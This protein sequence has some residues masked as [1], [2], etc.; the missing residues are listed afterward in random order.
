M[1]HRMPGE[2][3]ARHPIGVSGP[4]WTWSNYVDWHLRIRL[5]RIGGWVSTLFP[6]VERGAEPVLPRSLRRSEPFRPPENNCQRPLVR[7]RPLLV[8]SISDQP[9][10][11]Y[12]GHAQLTAKPIPPF[13]T[14]TLW[15]AAAGIPFSGL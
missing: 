6:M 7:E 2:A 1:Q 12:A 3:R 8:W 4:A 5:T 14:D 15:R 13:P 11:R 9:V 10:R